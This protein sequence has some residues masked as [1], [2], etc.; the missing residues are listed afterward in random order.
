MARLMVQGIFGGD[1]PDLDVGQAITELRAAGFH[2]LKMPAHFHELTY[3]PGDCFLEINWIGAVDEA[4]MAID[5][6][7][8]W[9]A[10]AICERH[11]GYADDFGAVEPG[12]VPFADLFRPPSGP[13]H[14]DAPPDPDAPPPSAA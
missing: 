11:G 7:R 3:V 9:E 5:D 1:C 10:N 13:A 8:W 14:K 4:G 12:H 2:V 6:D